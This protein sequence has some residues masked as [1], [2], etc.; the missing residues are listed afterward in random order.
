MIFLEE[1][2]GQAEFQLFRGASSQSSTLGADGLSWTLDEGI[3]Q[4]YASRHSDGTVYAGTANF[5]DLLAL[6]P[7]EMEVIVAPGN[8]IIKNEL[9]K[10]PD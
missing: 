5:A 10:S 2:E 1:F 4:Y 8:V 3:A 6:F 9:I 7:T